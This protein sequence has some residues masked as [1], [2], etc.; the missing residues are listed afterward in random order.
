MRRIH[1][2]MRDRATT[3][4]NHI[5]SNAPLWPRFDLSTSV[6]ALQSTLVSLVSS[7][8]W[9]PSWIVGSLQSAP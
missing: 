8:F 2:Y 1:E 7:P 5:F 3:K 4:G 9:P 6:P